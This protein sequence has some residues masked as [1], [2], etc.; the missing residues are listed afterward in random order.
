MAEQ[1]IMQAPNFV[2]FVVGYLMMARVLQRLQDSN[3]MLIGAII[4]RENCED[5]EVPV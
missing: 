1:L 3:D 5:Q 2:G 4:R